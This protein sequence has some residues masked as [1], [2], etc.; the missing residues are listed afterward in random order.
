MYSYFYHLT[1]PCVFKICERVI[2]YDR[3]ILGK[4]PLSSINS[5]W[6]LDPFWEPEK[7]YMV[8]IGMTRERAHYMNG[9]NRKNTELS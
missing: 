2:T 4:R 3:L 5:A 6:Y 1:Q 7:D 9:Q 8:K